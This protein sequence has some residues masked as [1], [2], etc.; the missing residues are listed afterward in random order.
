MNVGH[1]SQ[2]VFW[3]VCV[4]IY[5]Q[6]EKNEEEMTIYN[7]L[8]CNL[9]KVEFK[10]NQKKKKNSYLLIT[11]SG[12]AYLISSCTGPNGTDEIIAVGIIGGNGGIGGGFGGEFVEGSVE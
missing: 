10:T 5:L 12:K 9:M 8:Y 1:K 4:F 2:K 6:H 7:N 3:P 11:G